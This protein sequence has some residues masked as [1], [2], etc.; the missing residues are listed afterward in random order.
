MPAPPSSDTPSS[1]TKSTMADHGQVLEDEQGDGQAPPGG[2]GL[3]GVA[4]QLE[5]DRGA[6][7]RD[8]EAGEEPVAPAHAEGHAD[9]R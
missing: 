9:A 1:G 2:R 3:A 4:E 8:E 7:Q 5:D 6:A